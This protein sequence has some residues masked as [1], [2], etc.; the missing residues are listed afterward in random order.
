[1]AEPVDVVEALKA[2]FPDAVEDVIEEFGE[3]TLVVKRES[4]PEICKF[5]RD[6]DGLRFKMLADITGVDYYPQNPRFA[7]CYHLYSLDFNRVVRIKTYTDEN[8]PV[9]TLTDLWPAANW[10]ER[11]IYDMFGVRFEGHPDLRRLLM[12]PNWEGHPLRKDY[13]LGDEP[14]QFSFNWRRI[15]AGKPYV[16]R[17]PES[18]SD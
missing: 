1:M 18:D 12:P 10:P 3:L 16:V 6:A 7:V 9:P 2:E 5:L 14:T 17:P 11:E 8:T 15:D 4:V 13:P